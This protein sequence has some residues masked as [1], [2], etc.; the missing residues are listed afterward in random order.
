MASGMARGVAEDGA[1][2]VEE[3]A[4]LRRFVA[5]EISLRSAVAP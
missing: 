4:A 2:L 5:G 3:G 1:L